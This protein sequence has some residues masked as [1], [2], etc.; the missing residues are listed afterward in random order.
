MTLVRRVHKNF[1]MWH[2]WCFPGD[3]GWRRKFVLGTKPPLSNVSWG[4]RVNVSMQKNDKK[5]YMNDIPI[6]PI[7]LL[8]R[9]LSKCLS[10]LMAAFHFMCFLYPVSSYKT[11]S[12]LA[13]SSSLK[14]IEKHPHD[15][16]THS[17]A[18]TF[19]SC[20]AKARWLPYILC[21][22][23]WKWGGGGEQMAHSEKLPPHQKPWRYP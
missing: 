8:L 13:Y 17:G 11:A 21:N 1:E 22:F 3:T 7:S 20:G 19:Q 23:R 2:Q 6:G 10:I 18:G 14:I 15:I 4:R 5:L 12:S 9:S 16:P